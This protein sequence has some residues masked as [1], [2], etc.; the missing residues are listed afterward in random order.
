M[1]MFCTDLFGWRLQAHLEDVLAQE[2]TVIVAE[3]ASEVTHRS[4]TLKSILM[5]TK[6]LEDPMYALNLGTAEKPKRVKW[7][8]RVHVRDI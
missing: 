4:K 2:C 7:V 3:E 8:E 5:S 1:L 6:T